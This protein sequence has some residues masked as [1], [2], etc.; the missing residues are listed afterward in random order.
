M[1]AKGVVSLLAVLVIAFLVSFAA[2]RGAKLTQTS[3]E[4]IANGT[5]WSK[6]ID[7]PDVYYASKS[8][9]TAEGRPVCLAVFYAFCIQNLQIDQCSL[10]FQIDY[11]SSLYPVTGFECSIV[12]RRLAITLYSEIIWECES[13]IFLSDVAI[14]VDAGQYDDVL[15]CNVLLRKNDRAGGLLRDPSPA[16]QRDCQVWKAADTG[17]P[18]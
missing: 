15:I 4:Q 1:S 5:E 17:F 2:D 14:P 9:L 13:G 6:S 11:T 12:D 10:S 3:L 16:E 8:E 7:L 18:Q